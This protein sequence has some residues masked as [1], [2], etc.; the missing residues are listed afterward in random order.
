MLTVLQ[1]ITM[2]EVSGN[3]LMDISVLAD[4]VIG[5]MLCNP[6]NQFGWPKIVQQDMKKH[7]NDLRNL[8]TQVG[9]LTG[10]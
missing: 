6:E 5:P 9:V 10:I 7:V 4:E 1:N 3:I 2:G 8:M